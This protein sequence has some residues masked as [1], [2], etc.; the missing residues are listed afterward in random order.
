MLSRTIGLAPVLSLL[1]IGVAAA[2][3]P[4]ISNIGPLGVRGV[5]TE[6]SISGSGLAGNPRDDRPVSVSHGSSGR[7]G[8]CLDMEAQADGRA[9]DRRR[10]LPDPGPDR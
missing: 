6:V 8:R 7:E 9:G 2:A 4:Q 1:L 3:P 5:M 10:S